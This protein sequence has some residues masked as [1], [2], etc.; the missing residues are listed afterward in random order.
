M[1]EIHWYGWFIDYWMEAGLLRD[2]FTHNITTKHHWDL[3]MNSADL[4]KKGVRFDKIVGNATVT[5][6]YDPRCVNYVSG[7]CHPVGV[8][9]AERLLL[10]G[11]GPIENRKI[12]QS[13][14]DKPGIG[15]Y[16][17]DESVWE[18]LW[19]ELVVKRKGYKTFVDREGIEERTY[20]FSPE[21]LTEMISE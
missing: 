12:A 20:N 8:I 17:I 13:V 5:P 18:C 4:S 2:V 21:M 10:N 9:S 14:M 19:N 6:E 16:L 1:D 3:V 15:Q 7:G 11:T